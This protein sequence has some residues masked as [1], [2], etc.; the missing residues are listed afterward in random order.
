MESLPK[1]YIPRVGSKGAQKRQELIAKQRP[2]HDFEVERC[3]PL[4]KL[5]KERFLKFFKKRE[6]DQGEVSIAKVEYGAPIDVR[7]INS[8]ASYTQTFYLFWSMYH[9]TGCL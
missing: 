2:S 6:G 3:H 1:D 5:E 4:S 7:L 9:F 8:Q